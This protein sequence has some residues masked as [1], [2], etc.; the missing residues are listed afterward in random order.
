VSTYGPP[1]LTRTC[2]GGVIFGWGGTRPRGATDDHPYPS[3]EGVWIGWAPCPDCG[4]SLEEA[5]RIVWAWA[6]SPEGTGVTPAVVPGWVRPNPEYVGGDG[7]R[8]Y[9]TQPP[10]FPAMRVHGDLDVIGLAEIAELLDVSRQTVD[11][12][13]TRGRLPEPDGTVGGRPAW[14]TETI[15]AWAAQTGRGG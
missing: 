3:G 8:S 7:I 6:S 11:Q 10:A 2:H 13:R 15:T 4:T 1:S 14:R 9:R 12:W 5:E